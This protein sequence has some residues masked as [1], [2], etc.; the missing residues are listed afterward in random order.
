ME[1]LDAEK[2]DRITENEFPAALKLAA[3]AQTTAEVEDTPKSEEVDADGNGTIDFQERC[4]AMVRQM[5]SE[6]PV[7]VNATVSVNAKF[8][9]ETSKQPQTREEINEELQRLRAAEVRCQRPEG[10]RTC[11]KDQ[12][13]LP[14]FKKHPEG[15]A[16]REAV[17]QDWERVINAWMTEVGVESGLTEEDAKRSIVKLLTLGSYRL[18]VVHP[19]SDIDTLCMIKTRR[20]TATNECMKEVFGEMQDPGEAG[21]HDREGIPRFYLEEEPN[22]LNENGLS[23]ARASGYETENAMER[24]NHACPRTAGVRRTRGRVNDMCA[25]RSHFDSSVMNRSIAKHCYVDMVA[26]A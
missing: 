20:K 14:T 23:C 13:V 12:Q 17:L 10:I 6:Y 8:I 24:H 26:G 2:V 9:P 21:T 16:H 5:A 11:Q 19:G 4:T 7:L 25:L 1:Q 3:E 15:M 18:G 22:A